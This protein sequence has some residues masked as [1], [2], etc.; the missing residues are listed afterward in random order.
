MSTSDP[1]ADLLK[2]TKAPWY[3]RLGYRAR[4]G[5]IMAWLKGLFGKMSGNNRIVALLVLVVVGAV[6]GLGGPDLSIYV[7]SV[8]A[9]IGVTADFLANLGIGATPAEV[10]F[11]VYSAFAFLFALWKRWRATGQILLPGGAFMP[12]LVKPVEQPKP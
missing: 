10:V 4:K 8:F 1:V 2:K 7:D 9:V 6:K 12:P 11:W 5:E 3:V